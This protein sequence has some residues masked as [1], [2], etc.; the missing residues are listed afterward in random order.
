VS[1]FAQAFLATRRLIEPFPFLV[2]FLAIASLPCDLRFLS[3]LGGKLQK[4]ERLPFP[5]LRDAATVEFPSFF[6]LLRER[7]IQRMS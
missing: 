7:A 4:N 5:H 6:Q 3:R 2:T 1:A